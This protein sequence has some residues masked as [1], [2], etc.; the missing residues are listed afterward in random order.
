MMPLLSARSACLIEASSGQTLFEKEAHKPFAPASM[1]KMMTALLVM[2]KAGDGTIALTDRVRVSRRAAAVRGSMMRLR[3]GET[4]TVKGLLA[5]MM[6][7]SGND[8][9]IALAEHV[10][11]SVSS[12]VRMMNEK[13][14]HMELKNTHFKNPHGLSVQ[15]HYASAFD[16]CLIGR[17]LAKYN[18]VLTYTSRPRVKVRWQGRRMML[19]RNTNTLL[20]SYPGVDGLK[21]GY[22]PQAKYCLC[23]TAPHEESERLIAVVM[24]TPSKKIRNEAASMLLAYGR[25][26]V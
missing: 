20:A 14:E 24:G 9:A 19:L 23:A 3:A 26:I 17:E 8:A 7:A 4:I 18:T 15:G 12:F 16:M 13:A 1:T 21:T 6:V 10:G 22:T 11:G 2:E 5:G 25:K